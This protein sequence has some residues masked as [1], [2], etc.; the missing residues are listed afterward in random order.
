MTK[1]SINS[2]SPAH[3]GQVL[4]AHGLLRIASGANGVLIA[5]YL[6]GLD[7]GG[8]H[9]SV[10]LVGLLSAVSFAA[11]LLASIPMGLASDALS[12]RWLMTGGALLGAFAT[13]LFGLTG[14]NSIFF[15]SRTLEGLSGAAI[16]PALLAYLAAQT[17]QDRTLRVRMMSYFE[18]T[19]LAGLALGGI[20]AAQLFRWLHGGAFAALA[21]VYL[22]C[23]ILLF[24]S[25]T[26]AQRPKVESSWTGLRNAWRLPELRR[27]APVWL[28]VNCVIGLW[29][30]STLPFLLTHH[31]SSGQYLAGIFA[32]DPSRVGWLLLE[33]AIVFS[34]GVTA[35]SF[36]LP[37]MKIR[38]AMTITL[39]A[40]LPVCAGLYL[41]NH[42]SSE[43]SAMRGTILALTALTVMVESGFTP[44]ALAWLAA[45]LPPKS[46]K[47]AAMGIYSVLLSLGAIVGS[48]LAGALG[49]RFAID[50]LLYGTV[51]V[52]DFQHHGPDRHRLLQRY[53]APRHHPTR[54][55]THHR[56][57]RHRI[58][59]PART[60]RSAASA[61][62]PHRRRHVRRDAPRLPPQ[63]QRIQRPAR[64]RQPVELRRIHHPRRAH[65]SHLLAPDHIL[66]NV[67]PL[68]RFRGFRRSFEPAGRA[69]DHGYSVA[70]L[71]EGHRSADGTLQLFRSGIGLLAQQSGAAVLP[72]AL[73]GFDDKNAQAATG[74]APAA[75]PS[76]AAT[77]SPTVR[78]APPNKPPKDYRQ[79]CLHC[80]HA[81]SLPGSPVRGAQT[82]SSTSG[83]TKC[84]AI[85]WRYASTML[86]Q[87]S[88][89]TQRQ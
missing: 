86:L 9:K 62:L 4:C 69:L 38:R 1:A 70:I 44:A 59:R 55:Q 84:T 39:A 79:Q 7:N 63:S 73:I 51:L 2:R 49:Q 40:M 77:Q 75:S 52:D 10:A 45:A 23:A 36:I 82:A 83:P 65:A 22:L 29:L 89:G 60:L 11:E 37:H 30:G 61:P 58:R 78:S 66:F 13:V 71:P 43:S 56:Q 48:L 76:K 15:A 42:S 50:G 68:P 47:G 14:S 35:W 34:A 80:S 16:V 46:G 64:P 57:P 17:E 18:L 87:G 27:L 21:V 25:A 74:S 67:F 19:L 88:L 41:L 54:P 32:N 3:L 24:S 6:A 31:V 5:L 85:Q 28:C 81:R 33:Y 12:P 72:V 26:G 8:A 20:V 53:P